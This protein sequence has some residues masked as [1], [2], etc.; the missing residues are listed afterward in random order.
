MSIQRFLF[1]FISTFLAFQSLENSAQGQLVF[2]FDAATDGGVI[3]TATGSGTNTGTA[4]GETWLA[5]DFDNDFLSDRLGTFSLI[6]ATSVTGQFRSVN[7]G[8]DRRHTIDS[9]GVQRDSTFNDSIRW[10][11]LGPLE[12]VN[13]GE[14]EIEMTAIFDRNVLSFGDLI[15]GQYTDLTPNHPTEIF[16]QT[17]INVQAVP[18]A[19]HYLLAIAIVSGTIY[20]WR[21]RRHKYMA[22]C[23]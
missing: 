7:G 2:K 9:F 6:E 5:L 8:S 17:Q 19:P 23:D 22:V 15:V 4:T 18:E 21:N 10:T 1:V 11:N 16:G 13:G 3:V 14:F 12:F 20:L